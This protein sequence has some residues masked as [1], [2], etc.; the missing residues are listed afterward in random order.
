MDKNNTNND[1]DMKIFNSSD[2]HDDSDIKI[3]SSSNKESEITKDHSFNIINQELNEQT[4]NG[5]ISKSK[6]LGNIFADMVFIGKDDINTIPLVE[7]DDIFLNQ[8]RILCA[9]TIVVG[10]ETFAPN[11]LVARTSV[12][13]FYESLHNNSPELYK[14]LEISAAFSFYFL[15]IRRGDTNVDEKIGTTFAMLCLQKE[16]P[17]YIKQGK[18]LY[19]NFIQ[20]TEKIIKD[21]G[22]IV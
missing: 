15:D 22:F 4:I 1:T 16:N 5:N 10:I 13:N 17:D 18:L 6:K 8:C 19:N 14:D 12:S 20:K 3:F 2:S 9:L 7:K 21:M 11:H